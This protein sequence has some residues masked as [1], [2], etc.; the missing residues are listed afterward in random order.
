MQSK[1]YLGISFGGGVSFMIYI[2]LWV[3]M[4]FDFDF[5]IVHGI[6]KFY[7]IKGYLTCSFILPKLIYVSIKNRFII[8]IIC[9]IFYL[10]CEHVILVNC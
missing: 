2:K 9:I 3:K 7:Q 1:A 5:P 8:I 6:N 10:K 4:G